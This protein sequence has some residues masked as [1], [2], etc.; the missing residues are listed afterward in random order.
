[1]TLKDTICDWVHKYCLVQYSGSGDYVMCLLLGS[2]AD[3][4]ACRNQQ[5]QYRW[6]F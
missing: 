1:M 5:V 6:V 4:V 3:M 2:G